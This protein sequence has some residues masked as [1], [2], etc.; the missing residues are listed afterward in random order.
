MN[1]PIA[2]EDR[3]GENRCIYAS[4]FLLNYSSVLIRGIFIW[5]KQEENNMKKMWK[6]WLTSVL[7]VFLLAACGGTATEEKPKVDETP[8]EDA[9]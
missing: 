9:R 2:Y 4:G 7:A 5:K 8:Q 6:L 3:I 1:H